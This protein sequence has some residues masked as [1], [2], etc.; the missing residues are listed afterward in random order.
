M[1]SIF[2]WPNSDSGY[3][4]KIWMEMQNNYS[5]Y[6]LKAKY[7][8]QKYAV[9]SQKKGL[10]D[11]S[12][13]FSFNE[14]DLNSLSPITE[15]KIIK[16]SD[17]DNNNEMLNFYFNDNGRE[18]IYCHCNINDRISDILKIWFKLF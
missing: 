3:D 18:V 9:L 12:W 13:D 14:N 17:N 7:F 6:V 15:K 5:L 1:Y 10:Y 4:L 11:E 8:T 16:S 2:Y